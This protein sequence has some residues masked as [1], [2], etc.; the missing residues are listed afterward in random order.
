MP[1]IKPVGYHEE[2]HKLDQHRREMRDKNA[3]GPIAIAAVTGAPYEQV[4]KLFEEA[5]RKKGRGVYWHQEEKVLKALGFKRVRINLEKLIASYPLPHCNVLKN[6]TTHHPRR[7][8]ECF[9]KG[10]LLANVRRHILAIIDGNVIDWSVNSPI[11]IIS[12]YEIVPIEDP[13][14]DQG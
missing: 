12:L 1:A 10:R 9:P 4:V 6:V 2:F 11:R 8:K 13:K 5:G 14:N 3:C 7:F